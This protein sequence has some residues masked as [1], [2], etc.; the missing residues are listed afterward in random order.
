MLSVLQTVFDFKR[1]MNDL[2]RVLRGD[3]FG[4]LGEYPGRMN[5]L[6]KM[7]QELPRRIM[8][9]IGIVSRLQAETTDTTFRGVLTVLVCAVLLSL[10]LGAVFVSAFVQRLHA[11]VKSIAPFTAVLHLSM[12]LRPWRSVCCSFV[13]CHSRALWLA[14]CWQT[15]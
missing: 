5:G 1:V 7:V 8:K 4:V 11:H 10:G 13:G 12:T 9:S 3:L 6:F 15:L 2:R 14:R